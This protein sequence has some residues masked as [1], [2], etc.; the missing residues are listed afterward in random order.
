MSNRPKE[1]IQRGG[2]WDRQ[3]VRLQRY[4]RDL[5]RRA[6]RAG[7]EKTIVKVA[8]LRWL[9]ELANRAPAPRH[10]ERMGLFEEWKQEQEL[11]KAL[12]TSWVRIAKGMPKAN[13]RA[14]MYRTIRSVLRLAESTAQRRMDNREVRQI[15]RRFI[16][17]DVTEFW[18]QFPD[19]TGADRVAICQQITRRFR[20]R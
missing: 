18:S 6:E 16:D 12:A 8:D 2:P 14:E 4:E 7:E 3:R 9:W 20:N 11:G 17:P 15:A 13:A 5:I 10:R 19:L 1:Y